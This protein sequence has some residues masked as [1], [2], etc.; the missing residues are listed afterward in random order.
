[1]VVVPGTVRLVYDVTLT[2]ETD[3]TARRGLHL[4]PQVGQMPPSVFLSV[5]T[6]KNIIHHSTLKWSLV[7]DLSIHSALET[8]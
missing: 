7:E 2:R 5:E 6:L 3:L 8:I 4:V 1:M